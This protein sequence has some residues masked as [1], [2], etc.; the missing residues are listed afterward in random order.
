[1]KNKIYLSLIVITI[2]LSLVGWTTPAQRTDPAKQTW[3]YKVVTEYGTN[4]LP[5]VNQDKL[6]KMG[7]EGW[8]LITILS[9]QSTRSGSQQVQA[10]Y[11]FKRA[12]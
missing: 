10:E 6:N 4:D 3:E 9:K 5:P 7:D 8:E 12:K 2:F 11:Y 1:M